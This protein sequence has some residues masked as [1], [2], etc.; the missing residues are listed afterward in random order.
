MP[1]DPDLEQ[2][3]INYLQKH[4]SSPRLIAE[5]AR[6]LGIDSKQRATLRELMRQWES[7]GKV[8][9]LRRSRYTLAGIDGEDAGTYMGRVRRLSKTGKF[10]FIPDDESRQQLRESLPHLD[11]HAEF[12]LR[13][14]T[15]GGAQ[16]G[17]LVEVRMRLKPAHRGHRGRHARYVDDMQPEFKIKEILKRRHLVWEGIYVDRGRFGSV[18][19]KSKHTPDTITLTARPPLHTLVGMQVLVEPSRFPSERVSAEGRIIEV[20]GWPDDEGVKMRSLIRR[21]GLH[22]QFPQAVLDETARISPEISD[23]DCAHREDWRD[24]CVITIDPET[25]R[26]FDDAIAVRAHDRGWELA[27]HIADVSHY[28]TPGSALD[29]EAQQRGNSTY[30]P[31]GVLPML[32]PRLCDEICSLKPHVERLTFLCLM[33]IDHEGHCYHA[34]IALAVIRSA[35][36]YTYPEALAILEGRAQAETAEIADLMTEAQK[37]ARVLR[38]RRFEQGSLDLDLPQLELISN[39]YGEITDIHMEQSDESHELIEEFMLAA[40]EAVARKL[41]ESLT[42]TVYRIHE[43]PM[44]AKLQELSLLLKQYGI[45]CSYTP[46]REELNEVLARIKES[47]DEMM[48]K[49]SLLRSMMRARYSVKPLGHFGLAKGDYCHF[50]S[51]I[52]RYADL[53]VH[54]SLRRL[55]SLGCPA[56]PS[57]TQMQSIADHISET[58][59]LSASAET[60]A[61]KHKLLSYLAAQSEFE[62][63]RPWQAFIDQIWEMGL[64]VRIPELQLQGLIPAK[65]LPNTTRWWYERS[66]QAW[67]AMDGRYYLAGQ[68]VEVI[69]LRVDIDNELIDFTFTPEQP[70]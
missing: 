45:P 48:L 47:P 36:R 12:I 57:P 58:E 7:E 66:K 52:R 6:D 40:N 42:P 64:L 65:Q 39:E 49:Q 1:S 3:L 20:L 43:P 56:L 62:S 27:V 53:I 10:L 19:S 44:P 21:Y 4:R 38:Q 50:T 61:R 28:V 22:E 16:D 41:R 60:E 51:P 29:A 5:M 23:D 24:R 18:I 59:R 25:A 55:C 31:N 15:Q 9:R 35:R 8:K 63:P 11:S 37:L 33:Q 30:L 34:D 26:D 46:S 68:Q 13:D 14:H 54:R 32:P 17:D 2:R 70:R 67:S 69:P